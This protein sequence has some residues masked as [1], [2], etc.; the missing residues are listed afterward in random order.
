L[1][2]LATFFFFWWWPGFEPRTLHILCIVHTN[3]AKLTSYLPTMIKS[4]KL[5]LNKSFVIYLFFLFF[6]MLRKEEPLKLKLN[7]RSSWED[8]MWNLQWV[9]WQSLTEVM[10][11]AQW[12]S[13]NYCLAAMPEVYIIIFFFQFL[14]YCV[15]NSISLYLL[16]NC[17]IMSS[18]LTESFWKYIVI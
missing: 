16:V 10:S 3:W 1:Y 5:L 15:W 2:F 14:K 9:N 11:P 18:F 12:N 4:V 13:Q 17:L 6:A 7:L 8:Y